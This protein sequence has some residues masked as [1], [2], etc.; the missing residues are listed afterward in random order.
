[1]GILG[2]VVAG[3]VFF[4]RIAA[5]LPSI[6]EMSDF[7]ISQSTKI[8]DRTGETLLYEIYGEE[9]RTVVS[10]ENIP[11][12]IRYATIS[13]ED[14]S[15]YI[16]P[17]FDWRGILRAFTV[18]LLRGRVS[19]GGST[20]TQQLARNAFLTSEKTLT[21]KLRELMLAM[22]LEQH[23]SKD[24]ILNMYL[25]YI[26]YG[27]NLYGIETASL[28]YFNKSARDLSL[29]EAAMLAAI[30]QSPSYYSPWGSH[31]DE[32]EKRKNFVLK[33]MRELD[34]IDDEQL[35]GAI[36]GM[37][38]IASQPETGIK[39]PHFAMYIQEYLREKY[40]EDVLR[41]GGLKVITTLDWDLQ[42]IAESTVSSGVS[43]NSELYNGGNGALLAMD[44]QT[45]QILAMV[46]SKDYFAE[47]DPEGCTPGQNC[48]FEGNFNVA[49]QGLR[50]PGSALKPF[51]YLTAFE[52]GLTPN[53][54]I[55]DVPT[56]FVPS[57]PAT[58]NFN[59]KDINCYH[60]Q[61]F[62]LIFRG[63]IALKDGLAQS[64]NVPSVKV[65]YLAG[66]A[67]TIKTAEDFGITTLSD[68]ARLGLSLVLGGGEIRLIELL[69]AY[70]TLAADGIYRKPTTIIKIENSNGDILEEYKDEN[71]RVVDPQYARLINDILSDPQL[72]APLYQ[73]SLPLTIIPGYQ[74]ALKTGTTNDYV[75]AW[76]FGYAPNLA[77]GIWAGNNNRDP[78][79]SRGG[80]VLA[81]VPIWHDFVSKALE[82]KPLSTFI[83]PD[84]IIVSNPILMGKLIKGEFHD[85]LYYL[86]RI[87]DPQFG[88]WEAGVQNWLKTNSVDLSKFS[89]VDSLDSNDS[90]LNGKINIKIASPEN[91]SFFENTI[92]I[93]FYVQSDNNIEKV[94][95]YI[96]G[97]LV[98]NKINLGKSFSYSE[99]VSPNTIELQN[100]LL[101]RVTDSVGGKSEQE[102]IVFH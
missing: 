60:P 54:I 93:R 95:V 74:V 87:G 39:A 75:D 70:S 92:P 14:D 68:P 44:P 24:E 62:N 17:A 28:A 85:I 9:K 23:Y 7:Q 6:Q 10:P 63:P 35:G 3:F 72:R 45:G 101:I 102:L 98:D 73:N 53:T 8:Y 29:N 43:R 5:S 16:H 38:Q 80:S 66:L 57:C 69:G 77:V 27:P 20:I 61:N 42:Q 1:M 32:L 25:N 71:K 100:L 11:D 30:P 59:V 97:G 65:L 37:P 55:W 52:K 22:R 47:P 96:N 49:T 26:P 88:H 58:V 36:Q 15:F 91:G 83:K 41:S 76:A 12:V 79:T 33:R 94:E 13:I 40:G 21:R 81:A 51:A 48:R 90:S 34:Y 4:F 64:V 89:F 78:L 86:K 31:T 67:N 56:E 82:G 84:P 46:G 19:Q 99:D 18:N 2:L 50:Q